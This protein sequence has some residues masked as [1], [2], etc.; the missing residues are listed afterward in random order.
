[1]SRRKACHILFPYARLVVKDGLILPANNIND[2]SLYRAQCPDLLHGV[3]SKS[4]I[5]PDVII[6]HSADKA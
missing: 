2:T 4:V 1:M 6:K 5:S 3:L